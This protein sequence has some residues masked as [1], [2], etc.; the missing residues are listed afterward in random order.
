M[1]AALRTE[2]DHDRYQAWNT[3]I[4]NV[5]KWDGEPLVPDYLWIHA[6]VP[7]EGE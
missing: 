1:N 7:K 2:C 4:C 5:E 6:E 3:C